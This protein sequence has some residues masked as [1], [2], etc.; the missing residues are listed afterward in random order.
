M[1]VPPPRETDRSY[2]IHYRRVLF[3]PPYPR[4]KKLHFQMLNMHVTGRGTSG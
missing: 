1:R 3:E 4:Y 2:M